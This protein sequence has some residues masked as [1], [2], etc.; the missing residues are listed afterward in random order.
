MPTLY[1]M[2]SGQEEDFHPRTHDVICWD[3][4]LFLLALTEF[5]WTDIVG[6]GGRL[7][8]WPQKCTIVVSFAIVTSSAS[9]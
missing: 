2:K 7:S 1:S 8:V 4:Q 6:A 3:G 9:S 5:D